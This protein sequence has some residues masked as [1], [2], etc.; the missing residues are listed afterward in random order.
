MDHLRVIMGFLLLLFSTTLSALQYAEARVLEDH[1][2][3]VA[4]NSA[5]AVTFDSELDAVAVASSRQNYSGPGGHVENYPGIISENSSHAANN[6]MVTVELLHKEAT[7]PGDGSS[8]KAPTGIKEA[9]PVDG[10]AESSLHEMLS[11]HSSTG[12]G[13]IS[14]VN[15]R[16]DG[17]IL[18]SGQSPGVGHWG[19]GY[20][21]AS[22]RQFE[23]LSLYE[24]FVPTA[25]PLRLHA[26]QFISLVDRGKFWEEALWAP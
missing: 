1:L 19:K 18:S 10:N 9:A 5:S 23:I 6:T 16:S 20:I 22:H 13:H 24:V 7:R 12:I 4:H 14:N 25:E 17:S 21:R 11:S 8:S 26:S 3:N 15:V 2:P